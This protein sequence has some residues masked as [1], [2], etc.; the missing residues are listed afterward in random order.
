[1]NSVHLEFNSVY[2]FPI[3]SIHSRLPH[4]FFLLY[5]CTFLLQLGFQRKSAIYWSFQSCKVSLVSPPE[6]SE[7]L[8]E[9]KN[10]SLSSTG[11]NCVVQFMQCREICHHWRWQIPTNWRVS[12][13]KPQIHLIACKPCTAQKKMGDSLIIGNLLPPMMS[14]FTLQHK[15]C[16]R[17]CPC[18]LFWEPIFSYS[19]A[20]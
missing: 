10:L 19:V 5:S 14:L 3:S 8:L 20:I 13:L 18:T 6:V 7:P 17:T 12:A 1:M 16:K 15:L 4:T 2:W 11:Q 9:W